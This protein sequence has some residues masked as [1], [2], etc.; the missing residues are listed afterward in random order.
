MNYTINYFLLEKEFSN[1]K[2]DY[3]LN[4]EFWKGLQ[5]FLDD[6]KKDGENIIVN[7]FIL[8]K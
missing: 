3:E 5:Q 6:L 8:I 2:T 7:I 4:S 1:N